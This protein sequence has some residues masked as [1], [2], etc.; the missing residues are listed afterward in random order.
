MKAV[1]YA[2]GTIMVSA[3]APKPGKRQ[4]IILEKGGKEEVYEL[5][6][7]GQDIFPLKMG[8]GIYHIK[9]Y[10]QKT[11]NIYRYVDETSYILREHPTSWMVEPNQWVPW[12]QHMDVVREAEAIGKDIPR[13]QLKFRALMDWIKKNVSYDYIREISIPKKGYVLPDISYCFKNKRGICL[14]IAGLACSMLRSQ[15]I[16]CRLVIGKF[17][18]IPHAWIKVTIDGSELL[19][20]PT[21]ALNPKLVKGNKLV[22]KKEREY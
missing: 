9:L 16:P 8:I 12:N 7:T 11:F 10:E 1:R 18:N 20:D 2:D 3:D 5:T 14:D 19:Y 21:R 6:R 17:N 4:K 13:A 15:A 22:Y